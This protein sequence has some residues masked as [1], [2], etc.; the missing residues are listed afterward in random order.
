MRRGRRRPCTHDRCDG[1][2]GARAG[3]GCGVGRHRR[4]VR[5][6]AGARHRVRC[7]CR[8]DHGPRSHAAGLDRADRHPERVGSVDG[9]RRIDRVAT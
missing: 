4:R 2:G 9:A 8:G 3:A 7:R 6:T 5:T 1:R